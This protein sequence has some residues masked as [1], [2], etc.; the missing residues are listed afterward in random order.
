MSSGN[1]NGGGTKLPVVSNGNGNGGNGNG[2]NGN[3]NN[4]SGYANTCGQT[5]VLGFA[6]IKVNSVKTT[7]ANKGMDI[8]AVCT[9]D[10]PGGAIGCTSYGRESV[11]LVK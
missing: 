8:S 5:Q 2:G 11:A 6:T 1:G 4:G 9:A 3:G 10:D 7:G